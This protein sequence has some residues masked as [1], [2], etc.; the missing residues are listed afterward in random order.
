VSAG[1]SAA[2]ASG[3]GRVRW[4]GPAV[5]LAVVAAFAI[6]AD[7]AGPLRTDIRAFDPDQVARLDT[8]MWRAYYDRKPVPLFFELAELMR[9]EFHFPVLRSFVVA[10]HAARAAFV[11]KR[12]H[13]RADYEKALPDL[14]AYYGAIRRVSTTPFDVRRTAELEL[15]WWIVHRDS[16]RA[17]P[18]ALTRA[19]AE[20]AAALYRVPADSLMEYGRLRT[21]AMAIRDAGADGGRAVTEA[22]WREIEADLRGS[23]GSLEREVR[24]RPASP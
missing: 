22:G 6:A 8:A 16:S 19:L 13:A 20:G 11:F 2:G 7:L 24:A 21:A 1:G 23:W 10:G 3:S 15:E 5:A 4:R 18:A 14:V 17:D 9:R 12:G